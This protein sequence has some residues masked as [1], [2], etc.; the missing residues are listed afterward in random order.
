M[1]TPSG[2]V[3]LPSEAEERSLDVQL[4]GLVRHIA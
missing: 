3:F 1:R 2:R 4:S